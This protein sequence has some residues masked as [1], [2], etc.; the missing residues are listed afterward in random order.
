M[1]Q[2]LLL[3]RPGE[4]IVGERGVNFTMFLTMMSERL[5]EFD[6]EQELVEAFECFDENDS[7]LVKVEEMRKW[8]SELETGWMTVRCVV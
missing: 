6:P 5:F 4:T 2:E 8:L 7:G 3:S 1:M